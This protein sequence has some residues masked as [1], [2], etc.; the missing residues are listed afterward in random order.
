[1]SDTWNTIHNLQE[2]VKLLQDDVRL[3]VFVDTDFWGEDSNIARTIARIKRAPIFLEALIEELI[4]DLPPEEIPFT[5]PPDV[6]LGRDEYV[7]DA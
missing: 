2:V 7:I 5:D 6:V 4:S 1:M 3:D